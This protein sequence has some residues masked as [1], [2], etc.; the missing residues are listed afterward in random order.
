MMPIRPH[1]CIVDERVR[2]LSVR[3]A[4]RVHV[5]DDALSVL[6]GLDMRV[7]KPVG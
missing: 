1:G 7:V 5:R 4:E 3:P 2:R 6:V